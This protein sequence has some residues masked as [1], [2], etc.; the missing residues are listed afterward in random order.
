MAK[1]VAAL[2]DKRTEGFGVVQELVDHEFARGDVSFMTHDD[3]SREGSPTTDHGSSGGAQGTRIDA[4][5]GGVGGAGR[6]AHLPG[7]SWDRPGHCRGSTGH[8]A[9][10]YRRRGGWRR[11]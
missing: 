7:R 11:H 9:A 4:A 6:G 2:F 5:L 1:T 10:W 3:T 8:C